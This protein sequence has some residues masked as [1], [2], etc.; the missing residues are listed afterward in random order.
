MTGRECSRRRDRTAPEAPPRR[1][2]TGEVPSL[3]SSTNTNGGQSW[4]PI[5]SLPVVQRRFGENGPTDGSMHD[6]K[7]LVMSVGFDV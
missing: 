2:S 1:G 5:H 6:G 7:L 3:V 4:P